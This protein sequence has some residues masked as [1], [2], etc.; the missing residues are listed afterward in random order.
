MINFLEYLLENILGHND[1]VV[2][3]EYIS[4]NKNRYVVTVAEDQK[5]LLIGKG[6]KTINAVRTL[7]KIKA[8][9]DNK[10]IDLTIAE[11]ENEAEDSQDINE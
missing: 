8:R 5:S 3:E 2:K 7:M 4:D 9:P 6:G 1:F 11:N 10:L